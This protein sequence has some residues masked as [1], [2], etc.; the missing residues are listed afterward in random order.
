A[1]RQGKLQIVINRLK[2]D[3][4]L[5]S[6][7]RAIRAAAIENGVPLFT[8]DTVAAFLQVLES[9]SFNVSAINKGDKS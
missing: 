7:G 6:D 4:P 9:R 5:E 8:L 3:E 2:T 1:M